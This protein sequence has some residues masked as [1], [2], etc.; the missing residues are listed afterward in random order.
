MAIWEATRYVL[1]VPTNPV[2]IV[3]TALGYFYFTGV[4]TFGLVFFRGHYGLSH[5]AATLLLGAL[6]VGALVGVVAGGRLS[7]RLVDHGH[8]NWRIVVGGVSF[9]IAAL[10]FA[11]ALLVRCLAL[12][13]PLYILAGAA[14]GA[15]EPALDASRLDVMHHR[16]WGRADAVRTLLRR[17]VV[18]AAPLLFG[19]L[20][21][22][23]VSSRA[24][25]SSEHG[26]G[27]NA[28]TAGLHATF[29]VLLALL[30]LGGLITF[31]ALRT[32]PRDVATAAASEARVA[33]R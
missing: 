25:G 8:V 10:L 12:A 14:F 17:V 21:D 1:R 16:L 18:A 23:L 29:L 31:R 22:Q 7:D 11:P 15:R 3:A 30:A 33:G 2:L 6:G 9:L 28:S 4:Q 19:W 26:F 13:M 5:S 24:V 32:Y 20:A 27:A